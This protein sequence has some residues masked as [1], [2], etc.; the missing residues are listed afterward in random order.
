MLHQRKRKNSER[1]WRMTMFLDLTLAGIQVL[2]L[3]LKLTEQYNKSWWVVLL[4]SIIW[5]II[6]ILVTVGKK[7]DV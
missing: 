6:G 3:Y 7:N 2:L 1:S 5:A 4:P